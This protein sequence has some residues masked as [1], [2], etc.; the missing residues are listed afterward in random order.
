MIAMKRKMTVRVMSPAL[1]LAKRGED[2][3]M[4]KRIRVILHIRVQD[5]GSTDN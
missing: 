1:L 4:M 5:K 3:V 2:Q